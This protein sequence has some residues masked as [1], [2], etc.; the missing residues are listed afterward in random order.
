MSFLGAFPLLRL[1][2]KRDAAPADGFADQ[3]WCDPREAAA[4]AREISETAPAILIMS[5]YVV[6]DAT[7]SA[8]WVDPDFLNAEIVIGFLAR[9]HVTGLFLEDGATLVPTGLLQDRHDLP[10][11]VLTYPYSVGV[12]HGNAT[13]E[14][15]FAQ[16]FRSVAAV[17][18]DT[19]QARNRLALATSLGTEV[20]NGGWWVL[21]ALQ[22]LRGEMTLADSWQC[23]E[24]LLDTPK[25]IPK[26]ISIEARE[27]RQSVELPVQALTP[28]ESRAL[29]STL[30]AWPDSAYW[31]RFVSECAEL[32][33]ELDGH[34][35]RLH[36]AARRIWPDITTP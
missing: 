14:M 1:G 17:P 20:L 7:A 36:R 30:S 10:L 29:K 31:L 35:Q 25:D 8:F 19:S 5:E 34:G 23:H 13:P 18:T 15:A 27:T 28:E 26:A 4:K 16:G 22:S 9:S 33:A 11:P 12:A 3:F 6:P 2:E 24:A 32:G 21:G